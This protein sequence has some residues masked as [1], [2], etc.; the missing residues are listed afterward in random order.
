[1]TWRWEP[2]FNHAV[3][4]ITAKLALEPYP[5]PAGMAEK[6]GSTGSR[7][8]PIAVT[9]TSW[10][11]RNDKLRQARAACVDA[12][13]NPQVLNLVIS[14]E[15][16]FDLPFFGADLV[17]LPGGHLIALDLQPVLKRDRL[18]TQAVWSRLRPVFDHFR[19]LLPD[20]GPIP[21]EAEPYFSPC[22]LWTRLPLTA[23]SETLIEGPLMAAFVAYLDLY[24][25]LIAEANP[26]DDS[27]MQQLKEGQLRY[28]DYRAEKDPARGMLTR[29]YGE[30]WTEA[31]IHG[32]LFDHR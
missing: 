3:T 6:V 26:V 30:E 20:G 24:L 27:R 8:K 9:T 21:D 17:T 15:P 10:G 12:E 7:A 28:L 25:D 18:H 32:F 31:Y 2:F 14:P 29:F 13:P 22:F 1:M 19:A 16:R 4:Q 5:I 11:V 23:E